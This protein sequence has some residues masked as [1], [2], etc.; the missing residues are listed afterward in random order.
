MGRAYLAD[1][2]ATRFMNQLI[3]R[4][5][6]VLLGYSANDI[7]IRYLLEGLNARGTKPRLFAFA[8]GE[9]GETQQKW[10][11]RGVMAIPYSAGDDDHSAL[12]KSLTAWAQRAESIDRW[13]TNT[14][15]LARRGPRDLAPHERGQVASMALTVTG[16]SALADANPPVPAEWLCVFDSLIR[17]GRVQSDWRG[18]RETFDPLAIYRLDADPARPEGTNERS[19]SIGINILEPQGYDERGANFMRL[20]GRVARRAEPL[21]ARL[22]HLGR[23]IA[24]VAADPVAIWWASHHHQMHPAIEDLINWRLRREQ[25][26]PAVV[27]RGW[28]LYFEASQY[29]PQREHRDIYDLLDL[30]KHDGWKGPTLRQVRRVLEPCLRVTPARF[31]PGPPMADEELRLSRI[32]D[33]DVKFVHR[34]E[35]LNFPDELLPW[36]VACLRDCLLHAASIKRD[37]GV[38]IFSRTPTLH[39]EDKPGTV[40]LDDE[41]SFFMWFAE[42]LKKLASENPA[43]AHRELNQWPIDEP[44]YFTKL[45]IWAWMFPSV[46][47]PDEA[48]EALAS[49]SNDAFWREAHQRELLW[50]IRARWPE[51]THCQRARIEARTIEGPYKWPNEEDDEYRIRKTRWAAVRIGWLIHNGLVVSKAAEN[52]LALLRAA[53][54]EWR[55]SWDQHADRSFDSRGGSVS[56]DTDPTSVVDAPLKD[57][58][59]R[60]DAVERRPAGGFIERDPFLG[61]YKARPARALAVL[62]HESMNGNYPERLWRTIFSSEM[63]D[64]HRFRWLVARRLAN[65]PNETIVALAHSAC[66]WLQDRMPEFYDRRPDETLT[67]WDAVFTALAEAGNE[68]TSSAMGDLSIGG[69]KQNLSRRTF[70]HA[71]NGPVG[72]LTEALVQTLVQTKPDKPTRLPKSL[73]NRLEATLRAP[74]EGADHAASMIFL[75]L[76][77]LFWLDPTWTKASLL[78]MLKHSHPLSEPAWNGFLFDNRLPQPKLF[79]L[80]KADYLEAFAVSPTW[81]WEDQATAR[82]S[83]FLVVATVGAGKKVLTYVE[84]RHAL[85]V[86]DDD[87]RT[88]ALQQLGAM[89]KGANDWNAR[90]KSFV[91]K[92]WPQEIRFQ[93]S[94]TSSAFADI[95][96]NTDEAFSDA[97]KRLSAFLQPIERLDSIIHQLLH[98]EEQQTKSLA[99]RFPVEA[100]RFVDLLTPDTPRYIPYNLREFLRVTSDRQPELRQAQ[101]WRR[102]NDLLSR[103]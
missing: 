4:Y 40:H 1:G 25:D 30:I 101:T 72:E 76:K 85:R 42:L 87:L 99:D 16:S 12:W 52:A 63:P 21:P 69:V 58:M 18:E 78:P 55:P 2:W 47:S 29:D 23:W 102:L 19:Q 68:V 37:L 17:Y 24:A 83:Q 57:V 11:D 39:F 60:L 22:H 38:E 74:G 100:V 27:R 3:S 79:K 33:A 88:A 50:T 26:V 43:A 89:I 51:F 20:A 81:R 95:A 93:T 103:S 31:H 65:L 64:R 84:G 94:A 86:S 46:T 70:G 35:K 5:T 15:E 9:P 73:L 36:F 59:V 92:V 96:M 28:A 66:R 90:G 45:S 53:D 54:P 56:L 91:E 34:T 10:W 6:L 61:L 44:S 8:E 13:H 71:I 14:I 75:H 80:I 48:A 49:L 41:D 98:V 32:M 7:P 62:T 82:L 67:V 97:V 77:W